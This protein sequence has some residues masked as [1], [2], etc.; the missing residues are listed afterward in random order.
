MHQVLVALLLER[1]EVLTSVLASAA[2]PD[3][4]R[5]ARIRPATTTFTSLSPP[6]YHADLAFRVEDA[7]GK[8]QELV[9]GEVQ[10]GRDRRKHISW[11]V[12][13]T[14][15]RAEVGLDCPVTLVVVA[16]TPEVA[17]WCKQPIALDQHG[18]VV[19]PVVLG[20]EDI[21][22]IVDIEAAR[23]QPALAV[24]SAVVHARSEDAP[25]IA[26]AALIACRTLDSEYAYQY[27]DMVEARLDDVARRALEEL[28]EIQGYRPLLPRNRKA[29]DAGEKKGLEK[30]RKEGQ[31]EGL[32][33]GRHALTSLL[34]RLL[35]QRFGPLPAYAARAIAAANVE[36]LTE[37]GARVLDAASLQDILPRPARR[38]TRG[39]AVTSRSRTNAR[40]ATTGTRA[41][42]TANG[43]R[44]RTRTRGTASRRQQAR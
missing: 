37:W 27:A 32:E 6:S 21:P 36:T 17:R 44:P 43:T 25:Q 2:Q 20:P 15:A 22:R 38:R 29:F 31:K 30:G 42:R 19:Q 7:A 18:S 13:L 41:R 24:L 26:T 11:P 3:A 5:D 34:I 16:L 28:M 33:Q 10:L 1:P 12:Y 9:I 35:E 8:L 4:P 40:R 23:A 14:A 39:P